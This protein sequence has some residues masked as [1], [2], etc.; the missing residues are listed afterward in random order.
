MA[1]VIS[2]TACVDPR[3]ELDHHVEIGPFCVVGPDVRL[4]RGTLLVAHAVVQ[5][6]TTLGAECTLHPFTVTGGRP[7]RR[8][9]NGP[10]GRLEIGDGTILRE[11]VSVLAARDPE[12]EPARIGSRSYLATGARIGSGCRLGDDV[13]IGESAIL[14]DSVVVGSGATIASSVDIHLRVSLGP[15]SFVGAQSRV[16]HDVPPFML[17]QGQPARVRGLNLVALKRAEV[18]KARIGALRE[19][20]RLLFRAGLEIEQAIEALGSGG[21][22]TE[23]VDQLLE[24]VAAQRSGRHGRA[25]DGLE[26]S[27]A[28]EIALP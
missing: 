1:T 18:D 10:D 19:A 28:T 14:G 13:S 15:S 2:D 26:R 5:G 16:L 7:S 22:R 8:A 23:D 21:Y 17:V 27:E 20:Y 3:A 6:R 11:F 9:A 24:F 25:Q 12:D 4:G